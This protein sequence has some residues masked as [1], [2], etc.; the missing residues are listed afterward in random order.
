MIYSDLQ[1]FRLRHSRLL[2]KLQSS[3]AY[4]TLV[5]SFVPQGTRRPGNTNA[6]RVKSLG[7]GP[8]L[9]RCR[10]ASRVP[11][12]CMAVGSQGRPPR[13]LVTRTVGSP[14]PSR[15]RPMGTARRSRAVTVHSESCHC[16]EA[17]RVPAL[18][19][20]QLVRARPYP[21]ARPISPTA[22]A[23]NHLA[24]HILGSVRHSLATGS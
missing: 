20:I 2:A 12:R 1:N 15:P 5:S 23:Q 4:T 7:S 14:L 18:C 21:C 19:T 10:E 24:A 6:T 13:S 11:A 22:A 9:V 3:S 16:R 8:R 17:S